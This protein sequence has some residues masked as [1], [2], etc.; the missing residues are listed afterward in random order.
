MFI[1]DK[2]GLKK[3]TRD[4][5]I[6]QGI[7][8]VEVTSGGRIFSAFYSGGI[9]E[10]LN[11]FVMLV[12]SDDGA[13][14]FS[15]PIAVAFKEGYRCYDPCLWLDPTGRLWF[16]WS[17]AP[18]HAVYA[19]IC[20]KPDADEIRFGE[21]V[22]LGEDVM[23]NKPTVLSSGSWLFPIAV[24]RED[25]MHPNGLISK[26]PTEQRLAWA[27]CSSDCGKS[28]TR[29]GGAALDMRTYDEHMFLEMK[30]GRIAM[31]V[32]TCY[33]IGVCYS[34]DGGMTF[35]E[36]EDSGLGGPNSRFFIRRLKSGRILLVNHYNYSGR[37]H[38][39]AMLSEDD[40]KTYKYKLLIDE[41]ENVSY[42][43]ATE[44]DDGYIYVT[45]DRERGSFKSNLDEVYA[46]AREIL[47]AK[48]SEDDII[49]G[50]IVTDGSKLKTVISSLGEYKGDN[51]F[52]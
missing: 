10:E 24:W 6:W 42:P 50:R 20:E 30:D 3:F 40:G 36:G 44:A 1:T 12:K 45:Y 21:V 15:E 35:G 17:M 47:L 52:N 23:M 41:R 33:G 25:V 27:Y 4:Y 32:R 8:G 43:D 11:N 13:K 16:I 34:E 26:K 14:S 39:T 46:S 51:P 2:D 18:E 38:L 9:K 28:L 29:L 7:P 31:F 5:R 22:K 49:A 48:I 19:A 37:S